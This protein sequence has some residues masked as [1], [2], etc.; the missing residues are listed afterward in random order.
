ML[1][2]GNQDRRDRRRHKKARTERWKTMQVDVAC[3]Q[4]AGMDDARGAAHKSRTHRLLRDHKQAD[5]WNVLALSNG[6][7]KLP[8]DRFGAFLEH[9]VSDLPR[10]KLG[11]VVKKS[12]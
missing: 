3:V 6:R 11:L 8:D 4:R 1:P 2:S 9:Y 10:Y 5:G 12:E 7:W